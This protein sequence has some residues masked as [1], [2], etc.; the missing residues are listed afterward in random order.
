M[1]ALNVDM[2]QNTLKR[3]YFCLSSFFKNSSLKLS[4]MATWRHDLL[5]KDKV[6]CL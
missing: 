6:D 4:T 1:Y 3:L 2:L 5:L